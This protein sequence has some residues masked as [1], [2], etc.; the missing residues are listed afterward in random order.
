MVD[1][2]RV[3]VTGLMA[4]LVL[5]SLSRPAAAQGFLQDD[6][7]LVATDDGLFL[8]RQQVTWQL[9]TLPA[10]GPGAG[11]LW[12]SVAWLPGE[13]AF[14]LAD[15]TRLF[16][17]EIQALGPPATVVLTDLQLQAPP[18]P[19]P[20]R[21]RDLE[22]D[23]ASGALWVLDRTNGRAMRF[24]P[25]F[26]PPLVPDQVLDLDQTRVNAFSLETT[27]SPPGVVHAS[28]AGLK[29]TFLDGTHGEDEAFQALDTTAAVDTDPQR[30]RPAIFSQ[31][32]TS[33]IWV[34]GGQ[35]TQSVDINKVGMPPLVQQI[36]Q[37]P[38][39]LEFE[40]TRG[41]VYVLADTVNPS[42]FPGY[43]PTAGQLVVVRMN[44]G[45]SLGAGSLSLAT[46]QGGV[47]SITGDQGDLAV[48]RPLAAWYAH[49]GGLCQALTGEAPLLEPLAGHVPTVGN[50]AFGLE[51]R[52]APPQRPSFVGVST[53]PGSQLVGGCQQLVVAPR[54]RMVGDTSAVGELVV[55]APLP[56][57]PGLAGTDVYLQGVVFDAHFKPTFT[58]ALQLH[59]E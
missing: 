9:G 59:L 12:L 36:L 14:V 28:Q 39:A 53:Q 13:D 10:P 2:L 21:L 4:L 3:L 33:Q 5:G 31:G 19:D 44:P 6:D 20:L 55:A 7:V 8:L 52:E 41:K 58:P 48:V 56:G 15:G 57:N 18:A 34:T 50:A 24:D 25:P 43:L 17:L 35:P 42:L 47:T 38:H 26:T 54:W 46:P 16:R 37:G 51:F 40:P 27:R 32:S 22:V 11:P 23:P 29:R 30:R 45:P 1:R 49:T